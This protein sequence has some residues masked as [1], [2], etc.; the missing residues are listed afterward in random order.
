VE[1]G[2]ELGADVMAE[3]PACDATSD[4]LEA[5]ER[6]VRQTAAHMGRMMDTDGIKE[7]LYRNYEH[8]RWDNVSNR[9]SPVRTVPHVLLLDRRRHY[10]PPRRSRRALAA[11][12]LMLHDGVL[13]HWRRRS[14]QNGVLAL[15]PV[16]KLA[17]WCLLIGHPRSSKIGRLIYCG[18]WIE[19]HALHTYMLHA[20][21]F[22][23]YESAI[24]MAKDH[25]DIVQRGLQLKK[26]GNQG[27]SLLGG[28][29]IH[30]INLRVGGFYKVPSKSEL[31][32]LAE[33]LE[34]ARDAAL[35]TVR[36]VA[37]FPFPDF[38]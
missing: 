5:A 30:P 12:G 34:W 4:D 37:A 32:P 19:S 6:V 29:Q 27:V 23:G 18:E 8:P 22:L 16:D 7:L 1:I 14:A 17:S 20:P 25:R 38:E 2:T 35:E 9:W 11:L 31:A 36:W 13:L 24:H 10:R 3:V 15:S 26:T 28:R 21:D 33:R